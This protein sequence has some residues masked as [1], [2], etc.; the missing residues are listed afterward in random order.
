MLSSRESSLCTSSPLQ[1]KELGEDQ[2]LIAGADQKSSAEGTEQ[3][4]PLPKNT[5]SYIKPNYVSQFILERRQNTTSISTQQQ[6][7]LYWIL[8]L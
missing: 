6:T 7:C 4:L 3:L 8:K 2:A 5:R 1:L